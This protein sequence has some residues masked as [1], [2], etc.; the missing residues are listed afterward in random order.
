MVLSRVVH[1]RYMVQAVLL[2]WERARHVH[3]LVRASSGNTDAPK[4]LCESP[5]VWSFWSHTRKA[6]CCYAIISAHIFSC[7]FLFKPMC[8]F[9]IGYSFCSV[10][11]SI[12]GM[13]LSIRLL[14][15]DC[16]LCGAHMSLFICLPGR[17]ASCLSSWL[18]NPR[19]WSWPNM[20]WQEYRYGSHW[21]HW[22]RQKLTGR[23]GMERANS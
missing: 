20:P 22:G 23:I 12:W 17:N 5:C 2:I 11:G 7:V 18:W 16:L 19:M 21:V 10:C 3:G 14:T 9:M 4:Q 15:L 6:S 1:P 13:G 8:I